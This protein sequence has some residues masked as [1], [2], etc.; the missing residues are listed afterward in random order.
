MMTET[1]IAH[2]Y[3][4]GFGEVAGRL[5]LA[6]G[7]ILV[8]PVR[9]PE[10]TAAGIVTELATTRIEG[11]RALMYRVV[12]V[13][14]GLPDTPAPGDIVILRNALLD[15]IQPDLDLLVIKREHVIAVVR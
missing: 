3:A 1:D 8:S 6:P 15:P 2:V 5:S 14:P 7:L 11:T 13:A 9:P 4:R 12:A 10:R